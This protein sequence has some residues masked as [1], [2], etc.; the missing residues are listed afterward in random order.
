MGPVL[1]SEADA[2]L[3]FREWVDREHGA[4]RPV[5]AGEWRVWTW[6]ARRAFDRR[7]GVHAGRG[8]VEMWHSDLY[9]ERLSRSTV[10]RAFKRFRGAGLVDGAPCDP[11]PANDWRRE[12]A[13]YVLRIPA[14]CVDLVRKLAW[15]A[16]RKLDE[17]RRSD[18]ASSALGQRARSHLE[19]DTSPLTLCVE[20]NDGASS[21]VNRPSRATLPAD[22]R[23]AF[24][25]LMAT[26]GRRCPT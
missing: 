24:D 26:R 5:S 7:Y 15:R 16:K 20:P 22:Y 19:R 3:A 9:R 14:V 6:L 13:R 18:D 1:A 12:R 4:G 21:L 2:L 11:D 10:E 25:A 23:A 8:A 17:M